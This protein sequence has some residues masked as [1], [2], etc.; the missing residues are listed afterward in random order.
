MRGGKQRQAEVWRAKQ[1]QIAHSHTHARTHTHTRT[2]IRTHLVSIERK[3][4]NGQGEVRHNP[5]HRRVHWVCGSAC[6]SAATCCCRRCGV[7]SG[8]CRCCRR[9]CC[10]GLVNCKAQ[11]IAGGWDGVTRRGARHNRRRCWVTELN[12]HANLHWRLPSMQHKC[13]CVCACVCVCVCLC[14]QPPPRLT[15]LLRRLLLSPETSD[16]VTSSLEMGIDETVARMGVE[17]NQATN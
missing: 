17:T 15:S 8:C 7:D 2:H 11:Q 16:T 9:R 13:V 6:A 12:T 4:D 10:D 5:Q 3:S 14:V 1:A